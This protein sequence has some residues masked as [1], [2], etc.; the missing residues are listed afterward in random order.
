L[1]T[2]LR[3]LKQIA[4]LGVLGFSLVQAT[5]ATGIQDNFNPRSL[6]IDTIINKDSLVRDSIVITDPKQ[7]FTNL[8][9]TAVTGDDVNGAR[10]NPMAITFVQNYIARNRKGFI[11]MKEWAKPYF[12]MMDAVLTQHGL[13][14][15]LKYLAVIESGL[16]YNAIS[17]SGAVGPWALMP[18]AAKQYGLIVTKNLDERLDYFKSTHAAAR[19][20]TEFYTKYGDWLL[21][22]A[23]YNGGPGNVDKAI[24]KSGGSKDFWTIQYNLPNETMNHVKKFIGTHY[25]MEGEGGVTT[26]TKNEMKDVLLNNNANLS[27]DELANS[28]VQLVTGRYN[29][30]IISKYITMDVITFNRYNPGFDNEVATNSNY[31]LRLPNDKMD[32][33]LA[34]KTEILDE[35]M[36]LLL[37][38]A[39][40]GS[41]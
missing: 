15:E 8:F 33:F 37:K 4:I 14:K 25:I 29:S 40:G 23:A 1:S 30:L 16:K 35:S 20:L 6:I 41:N 13:P 2:G 27:T 18:A 28:R 36:Q 10:L 21:V 11:A 32:I 38:P 24:R 12:N 3:K 34:K 19:L 9:K 17:W 26:V 7:G 39:N 31:D 5:R 22:I